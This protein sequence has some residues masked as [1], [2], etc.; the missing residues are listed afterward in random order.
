MRQRHR[1]FIF[2]YF[3]LFSLS[4]FPNSIVRVYAQTVSTDVVTRRAQLQSQLDSLNQQIDAQNTILAQKKTQRVSLER[5]VAILDAEIKQA[6]LSIQARN[7]TIQGLSQDITDK[8]QTINVLSSKID[9]ER[10][11]LASILRKMNDI[12]SFSL[13][14]ILLSNKNLSAFFSDLDSYNSLKTALQAS[15]DQ[16]HTDVSDTQ[17]QK[18]DLQGQKD[19]QVQLLTIQQLQ[20]KRLDQ[21]ETQKTQIVT[22]SKGIEA[23]YQKILQ[24]EQLS[25]A[26]IRS[27]LFSLNGSAAIPFGQALQLAKNVSAK[28]N[29]Q[30]ALLLGIIT[31]ESNLG[32]NV[33]TGNWR[34]DMK[35]PRDTVPFVQITSALG[36]DPDKMP[37]SAKPWYGY[38]GAMGPAQFIPSTWVLY[39]DRI[40]QLTGDNPPNPWNPGDAFMAAGILL[41]DNGATD[42]SRAAERLAALRYLAGRAN[43]TKR[44]YAFYGDDVMALADKYQQ[45][46]DI[47]SGA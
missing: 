36:L 10:T 39:Q 15:A 3:L 31:E 33:G 21:E 26:E 29:I 22:L 43:A 23:Q 14:E 25:A 16:I 28:L 17:V 37:V 12:D 5:D 7:L 8:Q 41:A 24:K 4:F 30:P 40:A 19:E 32:Q 9:R 45:Q 27:E 42:H 34:T 47:L 44:A 18:N 11:A 35:A 20:K 38:G 2:V 46:I 1:W 6:Q 13:T